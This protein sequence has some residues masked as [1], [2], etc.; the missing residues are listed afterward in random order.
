MDHALH[1]SEHVGVSEYH[2][3]TREVDAVIYRN[4]FL[5]FRQSELIFSFIVLQ[6]Y[7]E[8]FLHQNMR[9]IVELE[10]KP[11]RKVIFDEWITKER[12]YV[13][14]KLEHFINLFDLPPS[15]SLYLVEGIKDRFKNIS[16]IRNLLAHGHE[17]SEWSDSEERASKTEA[18][19]ILTKSQFAQTEK[20]IN[21]L[22]LMWNE[23]LDHVQPRCKALNR[24]DDFKFK[25][26]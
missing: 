15:E 6:I 21:E 4:E 22:G 23:L 17:I 9:R 26:I 5:K 3:A 25:K 2:C 8:C 7:I 18:L 11:P 24:M 13:P 19:A 14:Q 12:R 10:F 1:L 16:D 20:E